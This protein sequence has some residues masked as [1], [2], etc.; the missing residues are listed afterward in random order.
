M[1]NYSDRSIPTDI[2][3]QPTEA[4]L[5]DLV[6]QILPRQT[7]PPQTDSNHESSDLVVEEIYACI[8]HGDLAG[9]IDHLDRAIY[10][11][12]DCA[13]LYVERAS[14]YAQLGDLQHAIADYDLAIAIQPHNQLFQTWRSQLA[15]SSRLKNS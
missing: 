10:A 8:E 14:F 12:P 2:D 3:L 1:N 9:A 11:Q 7:L 15:Q 5:P 13:Y 6:E 4:M